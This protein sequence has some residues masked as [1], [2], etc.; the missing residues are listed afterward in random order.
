MLRPTDCITKDFSSVWYKKWKNI[1]S[2]PEGHHAKF[3][4]MAI[5]SEMLDE[6]RC[7]EVGKK[8]LGMGVGNESL[9]SAFA[10]LGAQI[11]AT[12]QDP[13]S[14]NAQKWDNGQLTKGVDALFYESIITRDKFNKNV[15]YE[16]YNMNLDRKKYINQFDFIWHNCV[17]G[18][19][20]SMEQSMKQ[21][22]RSVEYLKDGGHLVFTT[23]INISNLEDT[24]SDNSDTIVWRLKDVYT[25]FES[26]ALSGM[27]TDGLKLR[28]GNDFEDNRVDYNRNATQ[29]DVIEVLKNPQHSEIKIPFG[30]YVLTQ[31]V[32]SFHKVG[33]TKALKS[34]K[35]YTKQQNNNILALE[36]HTRHNADLQDY[37]NIDKTALEAIQF[38]PQKRLHTLLMKPGEIRP[39][40]V[41]FINTSNERVFDY[42]L[43]TPHG[44]SPL[45]VSTND[46]INRDSIFATKSWSSAN[47]P[48]LSFEKLPEMELESTQPFWNSHRVEPGRSI[49]YKFDIK[50]PLETGVYS[51]KFTLLLEGLAPVQGSDFSIVVQVINDDAVE[52]QQENKKHLGIKD[53]VD[54]MSLSSAGLENILKIKSEF[55]EYVEGLCNKEYFIRTTL[56]VAEIVSLFAAYLK[57]VQGLLVDTIKLE[58]LWLYELDGYTIKINEPI[59]VDKTKAKDAKMVFIF[60]NPRSGNNAIGQSLSKAMGW[61]KDS[62]S[63]LNINY[64]KIKEPHI[65]LIHKS[66]E[67]FTNE[68]TENI[69]YSVI[70]ITRH[71]FDIMLSAFRYSAKSGSCFEWVNRTVFPK[72]FYGVNKKPLSN[73][74]IKWAQSKH[75]KALLA[76]TVSWLDSADAIVRYEDFIDNG[77]DSITALIRKI[78]YDSKESVV[79]SAV[80]QVQDI[81]LKNDPKQHRWLSRVDTWR[82]FM[83]EETAKKLYS[84]HKSAFD[85][86]GYPE[87]YANF[88]SVSEIKKNCRTLW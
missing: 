15:K 27:A 10:A 22:L 48:V 80:Q 85:A 5:I 18:H 55:I 82:L 35:K 9:V 29:L 28:L 17:I 14:S 53:A 20:G 78:G 21:L 76:T 68:Y 71:P 75:A 16:A 61:Q 51:E 7:L 23:E 66:K 86:L 34:L 44:M 59:A 81:Y 3:W 74:F 2:F 79:K 84:Y 70:T 47:R 25:M 19:L 73:D 41:K 6:R 11:V 1:Y 83:T 33:K 63:T 36:S 26:L 49:N 62:P 37:Y 39:V 46:P 50:A 12:D 64:G 30:G 60:A 67:E 65:I 45:V 52:N 40:I 56:T 72:P 13:D 42:S 57:G 4:E 58:R 38:L 31:V 43:H 32:L 24:I 54:R 69:P 87:P 8:G 88:L 77:V